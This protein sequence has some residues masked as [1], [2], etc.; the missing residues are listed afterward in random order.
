[1]VAHCFSF[2]LPNSAVTV[3][4]FAVST[5]C[6]CYLLPSDLLNT[7]CIVSDGCFVSL[8]AKPILGVEII[9][10]FAPD[11]LNPVVIVTARNVRL[12]RIR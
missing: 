9:S 7:F 10:T 12:G 8:S 3:L 6:T 5:D 2:P 1:M 4:Q 11:R